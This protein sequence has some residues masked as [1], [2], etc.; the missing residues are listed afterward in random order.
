MFTST[1]KKKDLYTEH[2]ALH[3]KDRACGA[4]DRLCHDKLAE[5]A[6]QGTSSAAAAQPVPEAR[7]QAVSHQPP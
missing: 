2:A 5:S 1:A 6:A 7:G 4:M 3:D